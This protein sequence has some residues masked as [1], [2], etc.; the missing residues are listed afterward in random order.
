M[1]A[2]LGLSFLYTFCVLYSFKKE[3]LNML[4]SCF[5]PEM[6]NSTVLATGI[7]T[8]F[9]ISIDLVLVLSF[10]VALHTFLVYVILFILAGITRKELSG[11]CSYYSFY[12]FF[13]L[14]LLAFPLLF[15]PSIIGE[16]L[17]FFSDSAEVGFDV[18]AEEYFSFF[19]FICLLFGTFFVVFLFGFYLTFVEKL[20][21]S[22]LR[23]VNCLF[24]VCFITFVCPPDA[25]IHFL[26]ISFFIGLGEGFIAL[27][28]QYNQFKK[29][30]KGK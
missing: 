24:I 5:F 2:L 28:C 4:L 26:V 18:R 14:Y 22:I 3:L 1:A 15:L 9:F 12:V 29:E 30:N 13:G 10:F 20:K 19:M 7:F 23:S 6:E 8:T 16:S 21:P 17:G 27:R 25:W 11:F